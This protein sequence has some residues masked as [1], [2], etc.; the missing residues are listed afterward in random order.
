MKIPNLFSE[1]K[2][3]LSQSEQD[4]FQNQI[5][6]ENN[7]SSFDFLIHTLQ[8]IN[9]M[10]CPHCGSD[11][12]MKNGKMKNK[13]PR[14]FC[15]NCH[16]GYSLYSGTYLQNIKKKNK[17]FDYIP[18][19]MSEEGTLRNCSKILGISLD[20]SF[21]W[22][23]KVFGSIQVKEAGVMDG[24]VE[25]IVFQDEIS[26]KGEK[27]DG[28]YNFKPPNPNTDPKKKHKKAP[29]LVKPEDKSELVQ[30]SVLFSR[31]GDFEMN[32]IH[33]GNLD[34]SELKEKL[35]PR[36]KKAKKIL[37]EDNAVV[38]LF[39]Q[40]RKLSYFICDRKENVKSRNKNFDVQTAQTLCQYFTSWL[41]RFIGVATKYHQN[42]M[43]WFMMMIK[44]RNFDLSANHLAIDGLQNKKGKVGYKE[45]VMFIQ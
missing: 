13:T 14:F 3:K 15:N 17:L 34:K 29:K 22:N 10:K 45:S 18:M 38:K 16:K 1:Q 4:F 24:I 12:V 32:V 27:P 20:T 43:K 25:L 37:I 19:R 23:K 6:N 42:Y 8:N 28:F 41:D 44:Y 40:E 39:L 36:I 31:K 9:G 30:M 35:Y 33:L 26:R 7:K 11:K 21:E 2:Q 5:H